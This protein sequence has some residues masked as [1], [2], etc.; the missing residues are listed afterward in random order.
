[1]FSGYCGAC[2]GCFYIEMRYYGILFPVLRT[3]Q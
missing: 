1:V 3:W 2:A